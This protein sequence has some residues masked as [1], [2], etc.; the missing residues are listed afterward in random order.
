MAA[1]SKQRG[2]TFPLLADLGSATIKRYG[3]LNPL[4]EQGLGP[5]RNDPAVKAEVEKYVS[6]VGVRQEMTGMAFPG[7]FVDR[8]SVV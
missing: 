1:F 8:K 4:P 3:I 2:I 7:T 5:N 6:V